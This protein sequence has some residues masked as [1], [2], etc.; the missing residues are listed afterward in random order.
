MRPDSDSDRSH[1]SI[2]NGEL[3]R[4]PRDRRGFDAVAE[5]LLIAH[6]QINEATPT[7]RGVFVNL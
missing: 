4:F 5:T 1:E 3:A 2:L 6:R 7:G